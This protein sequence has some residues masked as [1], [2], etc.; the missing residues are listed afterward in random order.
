MG[1]LKNSDYSMF[2]DHSESP[3][4]YKSVDVQSSL[5]KQ[6]T[7][8]EIP[9]VTVPTINDLRVL[10]SESQIVEES[11]G[12]NVNTVETL[13]ET[14]NVNLDVYDH[15][16]YKTQ[17]IVEP[18]GIS[19]E[20]VKQL[21]EEAYQKGYDAAKNELTS[22]VE[23]KINEFSQCYSALSEERDRILDQSQEGILNLSIRIAE[24]MLGAQITANRSSLKAVLDEA[25]QKISSSD[26]VVIRSN[27][28]D[29]TFIRSMTHDFE[30][31]FSSVRSVS[32]EEDRSLSV[33]SCILETDYG[34][35]DARIPMK[36]SILQE[37]FKKVR[38]TEEQ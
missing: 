10:P 37:A 2:S 15:D 34:F 13:N 38:L 4:V 8:N 6:P 14:K 11:S 32:V 3:Q 24:K 20:R 19:E 16:M 33:G 5:L 7:L 36:L 26:K 12:L 17:D 1:L 30:Q 29:T 18:E 35:V 9:T 21:E 28:E 31:R 23:S 22:Q 27:P 25:F